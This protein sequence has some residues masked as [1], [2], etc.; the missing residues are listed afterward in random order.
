MSI[1]IQVHLGRDG[2]GVRHLVAAADAGQ[3]STRL[4][5]GDSRPG[6]AADV[7][8]TS[9]PLVGDDVGRLASHPLLL[10]EQGSRQI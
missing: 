7:L 10:D 3:S 6:E 1:Q 8:P 4:G 5:L 9:H 2:G